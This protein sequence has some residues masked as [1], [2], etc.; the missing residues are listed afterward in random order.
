MIT[1]SSDLKASQ[2]CHQAYMKASKSLGTIN[3]TI[4][5]KSTKILL[6]LTGQ[7]KSG[8]HVL[9]S[10]LVSTPSEGQKA[11]GKGTLAT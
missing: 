3:C 8:I 4:T 7:V 6:Q 10:S 5:N 11:A 9:H 1:G 2:Q